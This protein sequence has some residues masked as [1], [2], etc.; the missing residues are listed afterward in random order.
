MSNGWR[1][2]ESMSSAPPPGGQGLNRR[3]LEALYAQCA[4][5]IFRRAR[6][7]LGRDADAWDAVQEVF[8]RMLHHGQA[9][10]GEARPMTWV[11]RI[12]TNVCLNVIRGRSLREP[13]LSVVA[14][15][16]PSVGLE[17]TEAR[18]LLRR[19]VAHLD[20]RE[21]TVATLLY[22]DGLSQDEV[23]DVLG[24]SRKTIG[25]EVAE[26]RKKA[27]ALGAGGPSGE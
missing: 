27:E 11:Y 7:L 24:M 5:V 22:I 26:L 15:E 25:R 6:A 23:A 20:E 18:D 14:A 17:S 21:L 9:F 1:E 8:E 13:M 3:E 4:P 16:E 10:R 19:W 12:T 2:R